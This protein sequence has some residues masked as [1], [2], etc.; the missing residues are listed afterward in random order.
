M[1]AQEIYKRFLIGIGKKDTNSNISISKG[2]F[3]LI[4]NAQKRAWLRDKVKNKQVSD[5]IDNLQEIIERDFEI[6]KL[7][8]DDRKDTFILPDD[9][10][11]YAS[12]YSIAN[13]NSCKNKK[14][15]N[16]KPKPKNLEVLLEDTNHDPSFEYGETI[17]Q[18]NGNEMSVFKK[19]FDVEKV[20]LSYYRKGLDIDL[21]GYTKID[22]SQS[23]N[24]NP[25]ISDENV[26][27]IINRSVLEITRI[28]NENPSNFQAAKDRIINEQ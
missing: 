25:D 26:D 23:I 11:D 14:I 2:E 3:V 19:E 18:V 4:F 28:Y 21:Q 6:S 9:Y 12:S 13:K 27:E 5:A 15:R 17:I 22:G 8:S 20:F 24:I 7:K 10:F 16:W 1:T